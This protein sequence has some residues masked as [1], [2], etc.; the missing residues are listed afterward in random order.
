MLELLN[1]YL[2]S[3]CLPSL[4]LNKF[5]ILESCSLSWSSHSRSDSILKKLISDFHTCTYWVEFKFLHQVLKCLYILAFI[6][7]LKL[8]LSACIYFIWSYNWTNYKPIII[9]IGPNDFLHSF[10]ALTF[11]EFAVLENY[12]Y[13]TTNMSSLSFSY[14]RNKR[15]MTSP[16]HSAVTHHFLSSIPTLFCIHFNGF[17]Y[18]LNQRV[19]T[20]H[21]LRI[22]HTK[23]YTDF[24]DRSFIM[25]R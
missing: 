4:L 2:W 7:I 19:D 11:T 13:P 18:F 23:W 15:V 5:Y 3:P 25:F 10:H 22:S 6:D 12:H 17:Q 9:T 20:F 16:S 24:L 1:D 14:V 8:I 21:L